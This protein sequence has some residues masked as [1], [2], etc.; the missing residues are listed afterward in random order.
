MQVAEDILK[1]L[2]PAQVLYAIRWLLFI[3]RLLSHSSAVV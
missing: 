1:I 2:H 3:D